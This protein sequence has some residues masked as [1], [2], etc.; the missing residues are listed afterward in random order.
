MATVSK[1][2]WVHGGVKKTAWVVRYSDQLGKR[3]LKTFEKKKDAESYKVQVQTEI[4]DGT[5]LADR[6]NVT[7][8]DALKDFAKT[9]DERVATGDKMRFK[10]AYE[11]KNRMKVHIRP[12]L[13]S[14]KLAKL[15]P[16]I[17]QDFVRS[18]ADVGGA[19]RSRATVT[20]CLQVLQAAIDDAVA[21]GKIARRIDVLEGVRM[22]G[23]PKK[24]VTIPT[25]AEIF[26]ALEAA[27]GWFRPILY[28]A[29]FTGMRQGEIRGLQWSEVDLEKGLIEVKQAACTLSGTIHT[30]KSQAG[31]RVIHMAP[32]LVTELKAYKEKQSKTDGLVFL[33]KDG[34]LDPRAVHAA[35]VRLQTD[36]GWCPPRPES[37][38]PNTRRSKYNSSGKFTFHALRHVTASLLVESGAS[39][40]L[41][42]SMMGHASITMT[43]STYTH[44]FDDAKNREKT[45][46]LLREALFEEA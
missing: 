44:S 14:V 15:T 35:W 18:V 43:H 41:I 21:R 6:S 13:G 3:R 23:Q 5:H 26:Q 1:R 7:V 9:L 36:L 46:A 8:S 17:I 34:P 45:T 22:V 27:K 32:E 24:K 37:D 12:L 11:W 38:R 28:M 33:G 40:Q 10:T 16:V 29:V 31:F 42:I 20:K 30:P 25:K 19:N 4:G 39:P 2:E